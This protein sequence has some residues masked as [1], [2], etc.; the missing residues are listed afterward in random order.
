MGLNPKSADDRLPLS[1]GSEAYGYRIQSMIGLGGSALTYMAT[2]G[3]WAW[4]VALKEHFPVGASRE[5]SGKIVP[6][7]GCSNYEMR[8]HRFWT[9]GATLARFCHP[10]IV[11]V[12]H[13]FEYNG[14]AYL[15]QELL[16]GACLA[17]AP[18]PRRPDLRRVLMLAQAVGE[19]LM[20][21]HAGGLIHGD[22][23]PENLFY[24][25]D[26]RFLILDFGVSRKFDAHL[27][28]L[29]FSPGYS[30]PELYQPRASLSPATDIYAYCA[31][32]YRLLA[33]HKPVD[34]KRRTQGEAYM[35]LASLRQDLPD[36]ICQTI[37][38]GL[39]L[40]AT[41]RPDDM[42]EVFQGLGL[43]G[44]GKIHL[45]TLPPIK[46]LHEIEAHP[47]GVYCLDLTKL[48][49]QTYLWSAGRDGFLRQWTWPEL[50][51]TPF[52]LFI[53]DSTINCVCLLAH[54]QAVWLGTHSGSLEVVLTETRERQVA[55]PSGPAVTGVIPDARG[56]ALA[57]FANGQL[58]HFALDGGV[59]RWNGHLDGAN[60]LALG[61]K[62][63][64]TGA[65]DGLI[66]LWDSQQWGYHSSLQ[67][68]SK[69]VRDL[70]FSPDG[71]FLLS[72]GNDMC[73]RLWHLSQ[74]KQVRE[75]RGH[76]AM[77]WNGCF[78]SNPDLVATTS[79]DRHLRYYC[80]SSSRLLQRIEAHDSWC[81]P[82]ACPLDQPLLA[83]GG[84]DG[85]I[86]VWQV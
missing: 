57:S 52:S 4:K 2:Q 24:T 9:E 39:S 70:Q 11:R 85:K 1:V 50:K 12:L 51:P 84:G 36:G 81:R 56:G 40:D 63:L 65:E 7:G 31:T 28:F 18:I 58:A 49:N 66:H 62:W 21:V 37:D 78:T 29:A 82:V 30:P 43:S 34:A 53:S 75:L 69:A 27:E 60:T 16:E 83:T 8:K 15:V 32:L 59:Q 76:R 77:V 73:T 20:V 47:G 64:A 80:L 25:K 14:N 3:P 68:H 42:A 71:R 38:R 41:E 5:P 26:G 44:A 61:R 23:K 22:I 45:P 33:G 46:Q 48:G 55:I 13:C 35:P 54:G 6:P 79:A 86:R 72:S 74:G 17:A 67:A 19:A 10:G